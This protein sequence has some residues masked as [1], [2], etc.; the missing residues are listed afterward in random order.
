MNDITAGSSFEKAASLAASPL[1]R[2]ERVSGSDAEVRLN[3]QL[4][5]LMSRDA[6]ST[7]AMA[8]EI[9]SLP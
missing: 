5:E 2:I 6:D 3:P 1:G 9:G 4:L 7:V 8:G